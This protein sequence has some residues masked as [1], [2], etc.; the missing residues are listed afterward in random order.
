MSD[1]EPMKISLKK[2]AVIILGIIALAHL[3]QLLY[4]LDRIYRWF[5]E[6]LEPIED[7]PEG[8]QAAIAFLS[9]LLCLVVLLKIFDKI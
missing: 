1:K 7:F 9:I 3:D 6:S 2:I 4:K 5:A 8:A